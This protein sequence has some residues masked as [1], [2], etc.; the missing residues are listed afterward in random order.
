MVDN[1]SSVKDP[2]M[3]DVWLDLYSY[4]SMKSIFYR[5]SNFKLE[6]DCAQKYISKVKITD[7]ADS[8]AGKLIVEQLMDERCN[9]IGMEDWE[10]IKFSEQ[11]HFD[12]YVIPTLLQ[13]FDFNSSNEPDFIKKFILY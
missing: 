5:M 2:F 3:P 11:K 6:Q 1:G 7:S 13:S 9:G 8:E 4:C 12:V 10:I